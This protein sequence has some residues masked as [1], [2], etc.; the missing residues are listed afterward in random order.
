VESYK[1]QKLTKL[2]G[3]LTANEDRYAALLREA[4]SLIGCNEPDRFQAILAELAGLRR[5]NALLTQ[6]WF[7]A[8]HAR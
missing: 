5:D 2:K 1:T 6:E 3:K 8:L 7:D 4:R